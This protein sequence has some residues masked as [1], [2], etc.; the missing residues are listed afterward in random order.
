VS[1]DGRYVTFW[2]YSPSITPGDDN[3]LSDVFLHDTQT[4]ETTLI[5]HNLDGDPSNGGSSLPEI[6]A[7]GKYVAFVSNATDLVE[8]VTSVPGEIVYRYAVE[9]GDIELVSKTP[10]GHAPGWF[11]FSR[12][13]S[14]SGRFIVYDSRAANIVPGDTKDG[15][16]DVFRYDARTGTTIK[17]TR[18]QSG[19]QPDKGSNAAAISHDGRWVLYST[20]ATNMGPTDT[21]FDPDA[22]LYDVRTGTTTLVSRYR[23]GSAAGG[24]PTGISD[25]GRIVAFDSQADDLV[26]ADTDK[27]WGVYLFNTSTGR[28]RLVSTPRA[29]WPDGVTAFGGGISGDSRY[30]AYQAFPTPDPY[31]SDVYLFDR[32][33]GKTTKISVTPTGARADAASGQARISH[34]G[35]RIAFGSSATTLVPGVD[36]DTNFDVFLWTRNP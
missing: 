34:A 32:T 8:G 1:D 17:V 25:D 4:G 18:T 31:A 29:A 24:V 12:G 3:G 10:T 2:T 21:D 33:A 11:A 6:S 23:D 7:N 28:V 26:P 9:T 20:G 36:G 19:G 14:G 5:S 35:N 30:V 16:V 13:I 15:I 22:Y 27:D